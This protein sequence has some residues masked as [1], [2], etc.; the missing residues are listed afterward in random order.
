VSSPP[1]RIEIVEILRGIA[2][3]GVTWFHLTGTHKGTW[4]ATIGSYGWLGV[5]V[6]FVISGFIVPYAMMSSFGDYRLRDAPVFITRRIIRLEPPYILSVFLVILLWHASSLAPGFQGS[7]PSYDFAQVM[8][9]FFYL[10]PLTS[11]DWFQPVYWTLA[12]EFAFYLFL[13][14]CLPALLSNWGRV[15][16]YGLA[17]LAMLF[18]VLGF[19]EPRILLFFV[20]FSIFLQH[21]NK[22]SSSEAALLF[23]LCLIAMVLRGYA[24][25]AIA[26]A[27][28]ALLIFALKQASF[29]GLAASLAAGLGTIS[30]SLYLVHVPIGGRIVNLGRRF[31]DTP[32]EALTV[33]VLAL[34]VSLVAAWAMW[35]LVE[36]PAIAA[37]RRFAMLVSARA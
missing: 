33:S 10:I 35:R 32:L 1:A 13:A 3:L 9:H 34:I 21:C 12:Y 5:D 4:V 23:A 16:L 20:G 29:S 19:I 28:A 26:G 25:Q 37:S 8:L 22:A 17:V 7:G 11:Y 14:L 24:P 15:V 6:F 2:S 30:Y 27:A 36:R 31:A 18:V